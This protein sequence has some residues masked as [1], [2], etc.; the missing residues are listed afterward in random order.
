MLRDPRAIIP[1]TTQAPCYTVPGTYEDNIEH[2]DFIVPGT[3]FHLSRNDRG[4]TGQHASWPR[5]PPTATN[6]KL[7]S[8]V[9]LTRYTKK[10]VFFSSQNNY[11]AAAVLY[12]MMVRATH[13]VAKCHATHKNESIS[14]TCNHANIS[15]TVRAT[16]IECTIDTHHCRLPQVR[17]VGDKS[18]LKQRSRH[19]LAQILT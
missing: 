3:M 8:R 1:R 5:N 19:Q 4:H 6:F 13:N 18:Q 11:G 17:F 10:D 12:T 2:H 9:S 7:I 16:Y 14:L 15:D